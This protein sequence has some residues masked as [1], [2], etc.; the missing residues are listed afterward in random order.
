MDGQVKTLLTEID[1]LVEQINQSDEEPNQEVLDAIDEVLTAVESLKEKKQLE[2]SKELLIKLDVLNKTVSDGGKLSAETTKSIVEAIKQIKIEAPQVNVEPPKVEVNMPEV[3]VPQVNVP[4]TKIPEPKVYFPD[5]MKIAKPSWFEEL[6]NLTP[7]LNAI[8][9]LQGIIEAFKLPID[10]KNPIS[11]RLSNGEKFYNALGGMVSAIGG[12][13][14]FKKA[15]SSDMA[16]LVDDE[17]KQY[18]Y[19]QQ[20]DPLH[21]TKIN[22]IVYL[23]KNVAGDLI[24]IRKKYGGITYTKTFSNDDIV[25]TSTQTISQWN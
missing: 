5:V 24:G 11:V 15:D 1:G 13:F 23:D 3:K 18:T 14:P 22:P 9:S 25:V 16:A 20:T 8:K 21:P 10:A 17:G 2:N 4:E 19:I 6:F 7:I 12:M